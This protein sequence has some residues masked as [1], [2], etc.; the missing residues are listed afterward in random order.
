MDDLFSPEGFDEAGPLYVALQRRIADAIATGQLTPGD[1]LPPERDMAAKTGLSRVTVRKAVQALVAQGHLVQKRGSGT[2]VAPK[3]ERLEQALS[4]LTSFSE[5]MAR[6]GK[7]VESVFLSRGIHAPTPE[8]VMALG[9]SA[10]DR[11]S[12]LERVRQTDG[13]PLAIERAALST[14]ILPD[15]FRVERSLYEVLS[16]LGRRPVRA[17]QRL[18]ATNLSPADAALLHL[19]AG[20]AGLRIERVS[21]LPSGRVV[22]FTR[23]LYRGDAYDF[24]VELQLA[25]E[26]PRASTDKD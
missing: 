3:V 7:T 13:V 16:E 5:D 10:Q 8:E 9:L 21:Y 23:S 14:A 25:P 11:V 4:L 20:A 18:S 12:R 6:R 22:E 24:A 15:P 17:V 26:T 2:F 19:P 1:S